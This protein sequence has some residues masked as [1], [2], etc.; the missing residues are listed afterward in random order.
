[1]ALGWAT[2]YCLGSELARLETKIRLQEALRRLPELRMDTSKPF[3]RIAGI[4][5]SV[6]EAHFT[7]VGHNYALDRDQEFH[8]MQ[9]VILGQDQPIVESQRPEELPVD[10]TAEMHVKGAD[11]GTVEYRRWL[12]SIANGQIALAPTG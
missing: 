5:D 2:H 12:I 8:D 9:Y 11:A 6:T 10:L 7:F 4:V 1:M 3:R